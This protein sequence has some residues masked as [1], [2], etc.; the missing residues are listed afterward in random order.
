MIRRLQ[1]GMVGGG[2]GA[3]IGGVHRMA[4]RLDDR[5]QLVAGALSSDP[6]TA[7]ASAADLG[8]AAERAYA[9]FEH[10][11][12]KRIT[13]AGSDRCGVHSDAESSALRCL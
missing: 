13:P 5:Y 2:R 10:M 4:A 8:I 9:S 3:F 1:L 7:K 6:A 11:G 12:R